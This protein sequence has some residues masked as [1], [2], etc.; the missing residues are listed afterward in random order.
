[1]YLC[2]Y[3][4]IHSHMLSKTAEMNGKKK[5]FIPSALVIISVLVTKRY[6]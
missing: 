5:L 4:Q 3:S 1:M 6:T 2:I